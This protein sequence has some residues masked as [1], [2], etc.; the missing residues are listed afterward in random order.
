M[1]I[2]AYTALFM[3]SFASP[4]LANP[5]GPVDHDTWLEDQAHEDELL[6]MVEGHNPT[7]HQNLLHLRANRPE[8]YRMELTKIARLVK[9]AESDPALLERTSRMKEL[10]DE[11]AGQVQGFHELNPGDQK[12]RRATMK[13]L[14]EELFELRQEERQVKLEELQEK[15]AELEQ[16]IDQR[17]RDRGDIVDEFIEQM[18]TER[19]EL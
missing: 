16:E 1:S 6:A 10:R 3:I 15:I 11:L 5:H 7:A 17:N 13:P 19:I 14:V 2:R 9:A 4:V 18:V 12:A 8:A